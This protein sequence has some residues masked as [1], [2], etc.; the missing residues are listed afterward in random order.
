MTAPPGWTD[1]IYRRGTRQGP[2]T[3]TELAPS[4]RARLARAASADWT[5]YRPAA[6]TALLDRQSPIRR[7]RSD[8]RV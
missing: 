2:P 3:R 5:P 7:R 1:I 8:E 6:L 4:S